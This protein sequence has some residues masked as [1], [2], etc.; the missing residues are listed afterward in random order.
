[1]P[2]TNRAVCEN[3]GSGIR[4]IE[5]E[6]ARA[7]LEPPVFDPSV[8]MF[9]AEIRNGLARQSV[10][11]VEAAMLGVNDVDL[12]ILGL[13]AGGPKTNQELQAATGLSRAGVS[14]RLQG[15]EQRRLVAPTTSRRSRTVRWELTQS[16]SIDL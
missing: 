16:I 3:R 5:R 2:G 9:V 7:G 8:A 11:A 6:L 4:L 15:M 1:M 10:D 13:L 12:V 14:K